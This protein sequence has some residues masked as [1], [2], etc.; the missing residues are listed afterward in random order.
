MTTPGLR[1]RK[2]QQVRE[3]I[4]GIAT[5]LFFER[6]FEAVSVAEIAEA[7][8]VSKMTVFNYFPRKEDMFF[9]RVPEFAEMITSA[10][11][12]RSSRQSAPDALRDMWL[13]LLD[14]RHALSG[15]PSDNIVH[16]YRVVL[17]SPALRARVRE[18]L[19][20]VE[21]LVAGLFAE[22]GQARPEMTAALVVA[23]ARVCYVAA[24]RRVLSGEPIESFAAEQ[25]ASIAAAWDAAVAAA[26]PLA[27]SQSSREIAIGGQER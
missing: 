7:A 16:F 1:E 19:E 10:V 22:A 2:K 6:G 17:A 14:Q 26:S 4:S 18:A 15:L 3:R 9:D 24:A 21:A 25:R 5:M 27:G 20:E 13:G 8:G 23:A 12:G 11:R